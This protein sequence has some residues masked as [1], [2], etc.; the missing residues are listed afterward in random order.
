MGE[1]GILGARYQGRGKHDTL[2]GAAIYLGEYAVLAIK[3]AEKEE[4]P[5][6]RE[7]MWLFALAAIQEAEDLAKIIT[8]IRKPNSDKIL[9]SIEEK[10]WKFKKDND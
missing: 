7:I 9:K 3:D 6:I 5:H 2:Y 4:D 1:V 8:A 10:L